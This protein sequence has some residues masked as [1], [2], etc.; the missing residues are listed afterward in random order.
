[1]CKLCVIRFWSSEKASI[2]GLTVEQIFWTTT[3]KKL[4]KGNVSLRWGFTEPV[5]LD[6]SSYKMEAIPFRG[7]SLNKGKKIKWHEMTGS[8]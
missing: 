6:L 4:E 5:G 2:K 7:D 8:K 3:K 1:M